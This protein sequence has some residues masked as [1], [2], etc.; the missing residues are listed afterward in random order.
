MLRGRLH[1]PENRDA[2]MTPKLR[3]L[4]SWTEAQYW[5]AVRSALRA[6]FRYW[7]PAIAA[8]KLAE[9]PNESDNKRLKHEYLCAACGIWKKRADVQIDHITPCGSLNSASDIP[10]F[11]A[12]LTPESPKAFQVLCKE[13]H[14]TKTTEERARKKRAKGTK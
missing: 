11:L 10:D 2:A 8:L 7:K 12:R 13:C 9:R 6:K 1:M 5:S 3:N 4:K 14:K